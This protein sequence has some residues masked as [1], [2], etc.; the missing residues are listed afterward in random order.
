MFFMYGM[1]DG[2]KNEEKPFDIFLGITA[3][4]EEEAH[5][6]LES[7]VGEKEKE[8]VLYDIVA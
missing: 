5:A 2:E 3:K 6:R 7:L 8:F 1:W 4:D